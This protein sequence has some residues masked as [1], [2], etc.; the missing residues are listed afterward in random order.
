MK[1]KRN[2][3]VVFAW[4]VLTAGDL[5]GCGGAPKQT[6][7]LMTTDGAT[8]S[9]AEGTSDPDRRPSETETD[10]PEA[11]ALKQQVGQDQRLAADILNGAMCNAADDDAAWAAVYALMLGI[12]HDAGCA[13]KALRHG[14]GADAPML[15]ALSWR[16]LAVLPALSLPNQPVTRSADPVVAVLAALAHAARG[17]VPEALSDVVALPP[18]PRKG[19]NER[20]AVDARV[21]RLTALSRPY[22]DGPLALAIAFVET[23]REERTEQDA[24]S[25][26]ALSATRIRGALVKRLAIPV[27]A[28]ARLTDA[29]ADPKQSRYSEVGER[30]DNRLVTR[31]REMLHHIVVT[32]A[33]SLKTAALRA[34]AV[35]AVEPAA[36]D[37]GA[38][39]AAMRSQSA[40][41]RL[42][43][44]RTYLLLVRRLAEP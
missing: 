1:T 31:P 26:L 44:A 19:T 40:D 3:A 29:A 38:A 17:D 20:K 8:S 41:V 2:T 33:D 32:G 37:L 13:E 5:A 10:S 28:S 23:R 14:A 43:A 15:A 6:G 4:M 18:A 9:P 36:G 21:A 24:D 16:W 27:A 7:V 12:K 30:L 11:A 25:T 22:D 39:A 42:E 34:L 35:V